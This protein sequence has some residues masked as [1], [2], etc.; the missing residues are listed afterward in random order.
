MAD[1]PD[2]ARQWFLVGVLEP[3][4]RIS[5]VELQPLPFGV[6]RRSSR[7]L[8]LRSGSV[9]NDHAEFYVDGGALWLRDLG[10]TNGTFINRRRIEDAPVEDLDVVHFA[11][12]QFQVVAGAVPDGPSTAVFKP[13]LTDTRLLRD[14]LRDGT[15]GV[16]FQ[17][18]IELPSRRIVGHEGLGRGGHP[19]LPTSPSELF[20]TAVAVG[21]EVE[22]SR[23]FR[24]RIVEIVAGRSDLPV[25]FVNTHP[26]EISQPGLLQSLEDLPRGAPNVEFTVEIHEGAI[27]NVAAI[28]QLKAEL[29]DRGMRIAYDDFGAG[30]ARLIELGEAPPDLLKFDIRFIRGIDL[31]PSSRR[32]L[33]R[34]LVEIVKD[35]GAEPVAEGV[36]TAGEAEAC[37]DIGFTRAQ[38]FF[39]GA[40]R[41]FDDP[42]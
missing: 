5:M 41:P 16:A 39:F 9:S 28:V 7:A 37:V 17:P 14:L 42:Q 12:M 23:L 36:E 30:Q 15:V 6:G 4:G 27:V 22:L 26:A 33:L 24:R 34:S 32:R 25:V 40:P 2:G 35:L 29:R 1:A 19:G 20:H 10:S 3:S 8:A 21:A 18:I 13:L 31:A 38:G 11:D